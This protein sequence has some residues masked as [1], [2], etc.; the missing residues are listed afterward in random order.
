MRAISERIWNFFPF[1]LTII[2]FILVLA[3]AFFNFHSLTNWDGDWYRHLVTFGYSAV[4]AADPNMEGKGNVGFFPGYPILAWLLK[5]ILGFGTDLFPTDAAL[6]LVSNGFAILTWFYIGKWLELFNAANVRFR[7]LL[8]AFYPYTFFFNVT[9]TESLF[10][11]MMM[12]F[13]YFSEKMVREED[14]GKAWLYFGIAFAHGFWMDLTKILGIVMVVYPLIRSFQLKR[15]PIKSLL[16]ATSGALSPLFFFLYCKE[17]FGAWD[18]Y[19]QTEKLIWGVYIDISKLFPP[20]TLFD[21]SRPLHADTVSKYVTI[22]TGALLTWKLLRLL[23]KRQFQDPALAA[24][25]VC[26]MMWGSNML[27]RTSLDYGGMGRYMVPVIAMMLPFL[28][29]E[30]KRNWKWA[31][32][33]ATLI[34]FQIAFALKFGRHGWVA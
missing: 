20:K 29:L 14:S 5:K 30:P 23:L 19:F 10:T 25:L 13:L 4:H 18:F 12:G 26:G 31:L 33:C 22:L 15:H 8:L 1:R 9:Y 21:F 28:K 17:K 3:C 11:A 7:M 16:V 27:G 6:L 2:P 24:V 32:F 34:G